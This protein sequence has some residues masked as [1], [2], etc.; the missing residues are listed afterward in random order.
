MTRIDF[1]VLPDSTPSSRSLLA[2]RLADKAYKLGH[3]IYIHTESREQA[4]QMDDLLWTF[5]QGSFLPHAR[6]EDQGNPAPPILIG[7][8][9]E[10]ALAPPAP[11]PQASADVLINL[12]SEVPLFFS[13]F[14][15]V[16]EIVD[17]GD[18]QKQA[19]RERYRFYRDR[20]YALQS[21]NV[22]TPEPE[23]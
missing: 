23:R 9:D 7:H 5:S 14:E 22:A 13:R 21:H 16:A 11:S 2:C 1:Y 20:G 10:P 15:R 8:G 12:A 6:V 18:A 3:H 17:Q 4:M 19:G